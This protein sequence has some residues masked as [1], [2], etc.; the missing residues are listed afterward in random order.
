M[1]PLN[2]WEADT[3]RWKKDWNI[4]LSKYNHT[5]KQLNHPGVMCSLLAKNYKITL[6]IYPGIM[7]SLLAVNYKMNSSIWFIWHF[8]Y[9]L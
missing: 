6:S 1:P 9:T 5:C 2:A 7:C 3:V 4:C 8:Y